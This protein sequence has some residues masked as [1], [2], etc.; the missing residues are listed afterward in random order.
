VIGDDENDTD[1]TNLKYLEKILSQCHFAYCSFGK[2]IF[3]FIKLLQFKTHLC[4]WKTLIGIALS[5]R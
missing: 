3:G 4:G 2:G 5:V 1:G